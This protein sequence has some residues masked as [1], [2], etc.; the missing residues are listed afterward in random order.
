MRVCKEKTP[1]SFKDLLKAERVNPAKGGGLT[2]GLGNY[3]TENEQVRKR[4]CKCKSNKKWMT[5]K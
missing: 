5:L 1:E 3:N 2:Q 4:T